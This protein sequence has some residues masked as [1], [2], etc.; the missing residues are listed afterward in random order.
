MQDIIAIHKQVGRTLQHLIAIAERGRE[1]VVVFDLNRVI[2]FVNSAWAMMHGFKTADELI[3]KQISAFHTEEQMTSDVIPFIKEAEQ[4]GQF[5]GRLGH[6]RGDGTP[7]FTEM[8]M[9]AFNDDAGRAVGLVGFAKDITEKERTEEELRQYRSR[10]E[11]LVKQRTEALEAANSRLQSQ[12]TE[13]EQAGQK[14][15]Q[16]TAELSAANERLRGQIGEQE[17]AKNELEQHRDK[18]EQR[19]KQQSDELT[20]IGAQLQDEITNLKKQEELTK[21]QTEALEAAKSEF[22]CQIKEHEQAGQKLKQQTA[23]LS[24]ANERLR[25][26]ISEQERAKNELE[27][28]RDK[29]EQHL[30]QQSDEL[31]ATKAQLQDEIDKRKKE[32]EYFKQQA[33]AIKAAGEQLR[34]QIDELSARGPVDESDMLKATDSV[35]AAASLPDDEQAVLENV[36]RQNIVLQKPKYDSVAREDS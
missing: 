15:R 19:L 21:Q 32:G 36:F 5:A 8:L 26:Q 9:V 29:L 27:Q 22:Q 14:L 12:V 7:F 23:D 35:K 6:I 11:E 13:H 4:K 18:L 16:Q 17:R 1:G 25:E 3:G 33:D 31:T 20:T 24:A 34:T 2:Q 30:R 28:D 10:M